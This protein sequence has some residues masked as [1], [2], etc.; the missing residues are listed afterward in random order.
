MASAETLKVRERIILGVDPGT[1]VMGYG[2]VLVKNNKP[3]MILMGVL[4]L[5]KVTDVYEKL[6][7]IFTRTLQLIDDYH[8]TEFAIESQF[9]GKN[10]QSMLKL[11]RAQG[12]SISAALYRGLKV[13]EYAPLKIKMSI[14]GNGMAAKEQVAEMLRK[15]FKIPEEQMPTLLDATDGLA[16]ALCHFFQSKNPI[17]GKSFTSW[18]DFVAKNANRVNSN[19][20]KCPSEKEE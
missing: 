19:T 13:S 12:V 9:Y 6:H 8:P 4:D 3:T 20:K 1:N 7:K 14:T 11:G 2:L 16:V 17:E 5:R 18:K 15:F 10:V